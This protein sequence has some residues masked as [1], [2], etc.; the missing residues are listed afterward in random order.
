MESAMKAS[1]L[2]SR[3]RKLEGRISIG[4]V[5]V[6]LVDFDGSIT[7][8]GEKFMDKAQ[9][10]RAAE[11]KGYTKLYLVCFGWNQPTPSDLDSLHKQD[12]GSQPETE[13]KEGSGGEP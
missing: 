11:A 7:F 13:L 12:F 1:S 4:H 8:E 2:R 5:A 6:A 3:I 10:E 9:V